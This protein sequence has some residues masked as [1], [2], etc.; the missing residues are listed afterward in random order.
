LRGGKR[1]GGGVLK[2]KKKKKKKGERYEREKIVRN[3]LAIKMRAKQDLKE[4][5]KNTAKKND[6]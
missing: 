6:N 1:R 4:T 5:S 2:K 3:K